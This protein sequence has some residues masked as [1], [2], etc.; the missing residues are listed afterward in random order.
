MNTARRAPVVD[1]GPMDTQRS[2][3]PSARRSRRRAGRPG[4]PIRAARD[5]LTVRRA[6]GAPIERDGVT[7]VPV[8]RVAGGSGYGHGEGQGTKPGDPDAAGSG[9]GSGGGFGVR[10]VPVGVY[11]VRGSEVTWQPAFDL[12]RVALGGQVVGAIAL[13][14]LARALRRRRRR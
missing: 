4:L 14:M 1:D 12:T 9:T 10:V 3:S 13:I 8:A 11:V 7:I 2:S 6:F 5:L